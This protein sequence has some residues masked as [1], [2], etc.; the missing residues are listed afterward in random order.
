M[1]RA[2]TRYWG[3]IECYRDLPRSRVSARLRVCSTLLRCVRATE[4]APHDGASHV[5]ER[6]ARLLADLE[7]K[8]RELFST[9]G[10]AA[11]AVPSGSPRGDVYLFSEGD[12]HL[13]V[14]RTKRRIHIR[15]RDH[16]SAN[17]DAASFP[18]L[19]ARERTGMKATYRRDGSREKLLAIPQ[20]KEAYEDAKARIRGMDVRYVREPDPLRQTLLEIYV[21]V[22]ADTRYND[23]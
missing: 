18:W 4:P 20:F 16:F 5:D 8:Y 19:I 7:T 15:V 10:I 17:Q 14:G 9:P 23:F 22:A 13:C 12:D 6:F 2:R 11:R 3:G 21:A 1:G